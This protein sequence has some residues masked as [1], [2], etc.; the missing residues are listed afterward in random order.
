VL[1]RTNG[2]AIVSSEFVKTNWSLGY[3]ERGQP[4]PNPAKRPS[5]DGT[6]VS[7]DQS[8]ASNWQ[9]PSFSPRTGL[10]YV[11]AARA[12]SVWYLYD[13]SDQPAGWGGT[14]RGGWSESMV[15]AIDYTTGKIRWTH[16]WPTATGKAG[17]LTTA[18]NVLFTSGA[19]GVEA[20]DATNGQPLWHARLGGPLTNAPITYQMDGLQYVT[21]AAGSNVFSFVLNR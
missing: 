4:I 3:D 2:R 7:P 18:G 10:F 5:I 20:L 6:L 16:K 19:G 15:Q 11:S 13:P 1:D 14:D 21:V 9:S 12:Y 17:I 8:G